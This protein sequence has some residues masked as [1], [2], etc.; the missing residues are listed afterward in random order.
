MS[1]LI[2]PDASELDMAS[3]IQS[4]TAGA[5]KIGLFHNNVT[6]DPTST[7]ATFTKATF[8][9]YADVALSWVA[10]VTVGGKA[11]LVA[12]AVSV[13]QC[14]VTGATDNIYG[15]FVWYEP[16]G[17]LHKLLFAERFDT[18]QPITNAGDE[19]DISA[20]FTLFSQF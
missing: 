5:T 20:V 13:F 2:V 4:M 17:G 16:G 8:T 18:M 11:T 6:P 14:T 10:P 3:M 7:Y 15:Y 19:I 9:G 12:T 1:N